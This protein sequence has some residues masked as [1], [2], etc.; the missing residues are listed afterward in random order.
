LD[1]LSFTHGFLTQ[2]IGQA[3]RNEMSVSRMETLPEH[4]PEGLQILAPG[5]KSGTRP[6]F[7][8]GVNETAQ[9]DVLRESAIRQLTD[10]FP[11]NA[12]SSGR[13]PAGEHCEWCQKIVG[14]TQLG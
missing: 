11:Q 13:I 12:K 2:G 9:R 8:P 5:K 10:G 7:L 1:K 3:L 6:L 4:T 14:K